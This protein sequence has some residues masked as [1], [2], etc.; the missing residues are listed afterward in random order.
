MRGLFPQNE[1]SML[2]NIL[3]VSFALAA[4]YCPI[5][6][7][8]FNGPNIDP[9]VW[10]HDV[11][12]AGG[13]NWE[14]QWYTNN[15]TNSF[16]ENGVLYLRPT[17]TADYMGEEKMMNGGSVN[18]WAEGCTN[19]GWFGCERTS[20]GNNIINPI[21]S[22]LLRT[23]DS[24]TM[25]YGKVEVRAK[26]PIGDYLWPAIWLLPKH[27]V[28]GG[29]PASGEIDI[30]ESRGNL[31]NTPFPGR[32]T[33]GSALHWGPDFFGN[34][35][36]LTVKDFKLPKG[37]LSDD[38]HVYGMEWTKDY[39]K[40]YI[41]DPTNV[42]L[43]VPLEDFF[44]KGNYP[45]GTHNPWKAKGAPFDQE[46]YLIMNVAVGGT[47]SYFPDFPGKPWNNQSPAAAREFWQNRGAWLRT[48]PNDNTRALAVDSVKMWREC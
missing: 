29:W 15:R 40:T 5:L 27:N 37:A 42:V 12:L 2:K 35:Y 36:P 9:K 8:D 33:F 25:K 21:R 19:A 41:D 17:L 10:R 24:V 7:D 44:Q 32:D 43:Q 26:L 1:T 14:F 16:I 38:F 46:F 4:N 30:M 6:Q 28:Y 47:G 18:L 31:G 22:A 3:F 23:I 11:T 20:N 34:R 45:A 39:I 48:W 13:G